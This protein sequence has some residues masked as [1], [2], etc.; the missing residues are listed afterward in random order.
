MGISLNLQFVRI[1]KIVDVELNPPKPGVDLEKK[2]LPTRDDFNTLAKLL[3]IMS[4]RATAILN[5]FEKYSDQA[6][7]MVSRSFLD[8]ST[9]RAYTLHYR[10]RMNRLCGD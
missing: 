3:G 5:E 7:E 10:T 9:K 8:E 2:R 4:K 1:S 6:E